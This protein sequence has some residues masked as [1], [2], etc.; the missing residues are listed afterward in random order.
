MVAPVY[1]S[2]WSFRSRARLA[3]S[4]ASWL[5]CDSPF[6]SASKITGV[7]S[8]SGIATAMPTCT[9]WCCRILSPIQCALTSGCRVECDG[10]GLQDDVVDA[11]LELLAD[12]GHRGAHVGDAC[13]VELGR[14]V[15]RRDRTD[16]LG[17]APRDRLADL[18][19]RSV[20]EIRGRDRRRRRCVRRPAA[21]VPPAIAS[22]TSRL[23]MRPPGPEPRTMPM[24]SPRSLAMRRAS[25]E[26]KLTAA[27]V[28]RV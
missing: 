8:P 26:A 7:I 20:S 9:R 11:D 24:S 22:S 4:R 27:R 10:D 16:G 15:E 2:G 5:I 19:E 18:R 6:E 14:E 28:D 13:E 21:A 12:R 17:Q 23:M 25:G 1:S 3:S